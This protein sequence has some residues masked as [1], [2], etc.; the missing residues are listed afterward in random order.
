MLRCVAVNEAALQVG[1]TYL[2]TAQVLNDF[3]CS[4]DPSDLRWCDC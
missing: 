1:L 4:V 2:A 3:S